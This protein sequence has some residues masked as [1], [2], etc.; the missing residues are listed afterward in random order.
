MRKG[1]IW[2]VDFDPSIG[3]EIQKTRPAVIVSND[4][5]NA[6]LNRMQVVP[7]T[8]NVDRVFPGE[9][10]VQFGDEVRKAMANQIM[11][12]AKERFS[13]RMGALDRLQMLKV[14][15][16]ILVQLGLDNRP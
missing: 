2:W 1:E 4:L 12:A 6:R 9:T 13:R 8:T 14:E 3:G 15:T 5:A 7:L 16:A 10:I 11:T